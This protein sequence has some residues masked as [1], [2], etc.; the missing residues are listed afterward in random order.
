MS[1]LSAIDDWP[2]GYAA[3]AVIGPSAT[4][5]T[6]DLDRRFEL[7][8]LTK[9]ITSMAV[10]IAYEEGSVQ[11]E[12]VATPTGATVADLLAH[13]GGI[14]PDEP[15]SMAVPHQRRIYST[16]AY[17]LLAEHVSTES[18]MAFDDYVSEAIL[19]PIGMRST[20]FTGSAGAGAASTLGDM[21]RLAECWRQPLLI[22]ESTLRLATSVH[23]PGLA[24][25]LPG[26]GRH[27]PNPWGLGPEIRGTKSPHWTAAL[28]SES[29]HGHFGRAGTMMWTDPSSEITLI[30]LTNRNF[31][32]WAAE[33]WPQLSDSVL[34]SLQN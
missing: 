7:A 6:G 28:N 2:V 5:T 20:T 1:P 34:R 17:D 26:F 12:T 24:G 18:G 8:S 29:T 4:T 32:P 14:A 19:D 27:D 16:S 21:M 9:L 13:S 15:R 31:G 33:A 11:L 3:A 25:V 23:M 30:A 10:L 22:S